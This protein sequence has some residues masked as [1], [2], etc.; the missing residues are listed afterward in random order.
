MSGEF[1]TIIRESIEQNLHKIDLRLRSSS[2]NQEEIGALI[3]KSD[4][5][6]K[7]MDDSDPKIQKRIEHLYIAYE[8]RFLRDN[9]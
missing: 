9:F 5:L 7:L 8:W 6:Y 2:A 4:K 3:V 1:Y